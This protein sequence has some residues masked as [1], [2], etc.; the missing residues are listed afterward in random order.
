MVRLHPPNS[1]DWFLELLTVPD[2][3]SLPG[4]NWTRL[5]MQDGHYGIPS[6]RFLSVATFNPVKTEFGVFCARAEMMALANLLENPKIKPAPMKG[7]IEGRQIKRSNKDL[8]RVLAIASLTAEEH[9]LAWPDA[10]G[11]SLRE[12][13]PSEWGAHARRTGAGLRELLASEEDLEQAHYCC[14]NGLL[15]SR[16][17]TIERLRLQG[18]RLIQDAIEPFEQQA[19]R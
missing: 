11:E 10:W 9:V 3:S 17:V 1:K 2:C 7:L 14:I 5:E 16:H 15:A 13:F 12:I 19:T 6:F 18:L 8:S 4:K